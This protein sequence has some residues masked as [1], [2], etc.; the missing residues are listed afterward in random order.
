MAGYYDE[1][2]GQF[3]DTGNVGVLQGPL[4]NTSGTSGNSFVSNL[5]DFGKRLLTGDATASEYGKAAA[6]LGGLYGASR[7]SA[8]TVIN[9]GY[10]GGIPE[11]KATRTMLTE[12][13]AGR[14]PGSGGI[15]YGGDVT[16]TRTGQIL[17]AG[18]IGQSTPQSQPLGGTPT[19]TQPSAYDL[20]SMA[21][22]IEKVRQYES[23]IGRPLSSAAPAPAAPAPAAAA[24]SQAPAGAQ[25]VSDAQRLYNTAI[26]NPQFSSGLPA[27]QTGPRFTPMEQQMRND[28][29][30]YFATTKPGSYYDVAG[31]TL[32]RADP[33]RAIFITPQ[34]E[35]TLHRN[36][37]IAD[38]AAT[39]PEF[40]KAWEEVYGYKATGP[41]PAS[42]V[43]T[44]DNWN[45]IRQV[46]AEASRDPYASRRSIALDPQL[47]AVDLS[48]YR[49]NPHGAFEELARQVYGDKGMTLQDIARLSEAVGAVGSYRQ[50]PDGRYY[51]T[52][53]SPFAQGVVPQGGY[54][55]EQLRQI[56]RGAMG[57][58]AQG[59]LAADG[60][61]IPADV[62]SHFGN[63]SSEAGLEFLAEE[64][65]A[66]P[67][68]G[69][70]DGMSDSIPTTIEGKQPARVA[71]DEAFV[72]PEVVKRLGNGDTERGA[73]KLY[74][75]MDRIRKART[76][77]TEQGKQINPEKFMPGGKV[78]RFS[79]G[80]TTGT[81]GGIAS[82]SLS[83]WAGPY[84]AD[85][86]GKGKALTEMPYAAYTG[87]LTAGESPLQQQAFAAASQYQVPT[88][89]GAAGTTAGGI[90]SKAQG[91]SYT[92]VGQSFTGMVGGAAPAT[93]T[94]GIAAPPSGS[95]TAPSS[96]YGVPTSSDGQWFFA[97]GK[98]QPNQTASMSPMTTSEMQQ[99]ATQQGLPAAQSIAQ[100][101]MS[102]YI[103]NVLNVQTQEAKRQA[104]IEGQKLGAM[105]ARSGAFGGGRDAIMRSQA[106]ADLQR[107]LAGI[108]ATGLQSAYDKAMQQFNT[109]QA[110]KI[111][112]A[113][114]GAGFGLQGLQ[115]GL[116]AAESQ[117]R[118]G[119]TEAA[120]GLDRIRTLADLGGVQ[121]GIEAEG[122]AADKAQ[123]EEARLNPFKML[124]FQQSL[125]SGLPL[126]S[127]SLYQPG[128]S[129][130]DQFASGFTTI[131]KLLEAL[132]LN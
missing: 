93:S 85:L 107:N 12:P 113:Q 114:F 79:N 34:G 26:A 59:G 15:N 128:T 55:Q 96:E 48:A 50:G 23:Q 95:Y 131:N 66:K 19:F 14:R 8:P 70:G 110:R 90:A 87:L 104:D 109:E 122:V 126:A 77:T 130:L 108:Q 67:I 91:L 43:M 84:V 51:L 118:L 124:Q 52:S 112:E 38:I 49:D 69:E 17:G 106:A 4:D 10:Q 37:Q 121:R 123:F 18:N 83:S 29:E 127:Q 21:S 120:A 88:G 80:G 73:K 97:D 11:V 65:N 105:A 44:A 71:N 33:D 132:D 116:Q 41:T 46:Y 64:L 22:L 25:T 9:P 102:P 32:Y 54:T 76:G 74:A 6:L 92:P 111:Q 68:K 30:A 35:Y 75:M 89:I 60:F 63:G 57:G 58:L 7:S 5:A 81:T 42:G 86:L 3:I 129:N 36:T 82:E 99:P 20:E 56:E 101:Y 39:I 62:V 13:P 45:P 115:T 31:G 100:Q 61:V 1:I 125:L 40:A 16:Y 117:G 78:E 53:Q 119:A 2:T 27:A 98:W 94:G 24:P 72:P 103:Q 47:R 28:Y